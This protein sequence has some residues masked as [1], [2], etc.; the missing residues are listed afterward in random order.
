MQTAK[1]RS[2]IECILTI[3]FLICFLT[4]VIPT[5]LFAQSSLSI[6]PE[7]KR[8]AINQVM[9]QVGLSLKKYEGVNRVAILKFTNDPDNQVQKHFTEKL[10]ELHLYQVI[11][12]QHL[13]IIFAEAEF[14]ETNI[15]DPET[16]VKAG[17]IAGAEAVF[18]GE[19]N[20]ITTSSKI[21]IS[22]FFKM[23]KVSDGTILWS[24]NPE[25]VASPAVTKKAAKLAPYILFVLLIL[26]IIF[27][28]LGRIKSSK[29]RI[30]EKLRISEKEEESTFN[31]AGTLKRIKNVL[32][33]AI[34]TGYDNESM[35]EA[36]KVMDE[37]FRNIGLMEI[38]L[39]NHRA[40]FD[41]SKHNTIDSKLREIHTAVENIRT[42]MDANNDTNIKNY[43]RTGNNLLEDIR[44]L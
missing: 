16:A 23:I 42:D 6:D 17:K 7:L 43:T 2:D 44:Q 22:A 25:G 8:Q 21:R 5:C 27:V 19:I 33:E 32:Q 36:C 30:E 10:T 41:S 29:T 14:H 26:V 37:L 1:P 20:S 15:I 28:G 13:D 34:N 39:T 3:L 18:Y 4:S 24:A 31:H 38:Y 11:E 40:K 12:R 9:T 35:K